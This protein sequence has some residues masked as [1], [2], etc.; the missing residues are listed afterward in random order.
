[1][2][3]PTDS[4]HPNARSGAK[5]SKTVSQGF[6]LIELLVVIA[7]IAIL[8]AILFPV[9]GRARENARR[10]SCQSNLKQIALGVMQYKQDYDEK[11]PLATTL[12]VPGSIGWATATQPYLKSIQIFQCPS[13]PGSSTDL[14]NPTVAGTSYTDYWYNAILSWNGETTA[15]N[16]S[17]G[18]SEAALLSSS[19]TV[20]AGDGTPAGTNPGSARY[21]V[22]GCGSNV[23][24]TASAPD[25]G[26]CGS[27][28]SGATKFVTT[29]GLGGA[30]S[31]VRH[32]DG[33]N[34]AFADGH[35]KWYK[36]ANP[37]ATQGNVIGTNQVYNS[38]YGFN[39]SGQSPTFNAV[40]QNDL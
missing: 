12:N 1:M 5:R 33:F 4:N 40:N 38:L 37:D 2:H 29:G 11:F 19:L 28:P 24:S 27:T 8:A 36:G 16:Y 3:T 10:S 30:G 39:T 18:V 14:P 17:T 7:I 20:M 32:L 26:N 6:T 35:V 13:E 25:F 15:P 23:S 9:F 22:N 31:Q 34:L 21:R